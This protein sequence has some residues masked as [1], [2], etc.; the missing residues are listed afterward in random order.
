VFPGAYH[1]NKKPYAFIYIGEI[2]AIVNRA[3]CMFW[4]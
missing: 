3:E 4:N 2:T 1:N